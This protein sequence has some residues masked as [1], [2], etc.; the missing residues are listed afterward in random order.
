MEDMMSTLDDAKPS[1]CDECDEMWVD[2][3]GCPAGSASASAEAS[4][5]ARVLLA[6]KFGVAEEMNSV[7][8][9][10]FLADECKDEKAEKLFVWADLPKEQQDAMRAPMCAL[11]HLAGSMMGAVLGKCKSNFEGQSDWTDA[12]ATAYNADRKAM[13]AECVEMGCKDVMGESCDSA[14][15]AAGNAATWADIKSSGS[16]AYIMSLSM[17]IAIIMMVFRY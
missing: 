4:A 6:E 13:E 2:M 9:Y 10:R 14:M 7:K 3:K 1:G 16:N 11:Q 12:H 15:T 17:L 8:G 5:S